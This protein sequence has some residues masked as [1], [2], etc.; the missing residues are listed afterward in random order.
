[1]SAVDGQVRVFFD[2]PLVFS[3]YSY[4]C[5]EVLDGQGVTIQFCS[6]VTSSMINVSLLPPMSRFKEQAKAGGKE[7]LLT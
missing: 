3:D 1:M 6:A 5:M 2:A 7:E 4:T